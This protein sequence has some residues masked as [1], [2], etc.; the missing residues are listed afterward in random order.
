MLALSL[1]NP[2][3]AINLR[4]ATLNSVFSIFPTDASGEMTSLASGLTAMLTFTPSTES[5]SGLDLLAAVAST[6]SASGDTLMLQQEGTGLSKNGLTPKVAKKIFGPIEFVE[7]LEVTMD[8][9][10]E[11]SIARPFLRDYPPVT[12]ILQ[13]TER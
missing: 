10:Q 7:M 8:A 5:H 9:P 1:T 3:H 4:Y 2:H 12:S 11:P 13:W 6:S